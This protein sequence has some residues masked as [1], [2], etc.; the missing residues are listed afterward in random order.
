MARPSAPRFL[1]FGDRFELPVVLQ[2]QTNAPLEVEVVVRT[3]NL[4]LSAATAPSPDGGDNTSYAGLRVTVPA[5][6]RIEVRFPATTAMAGTARL[7][8]A[9]VSGDYSDA[10]I[11]ELPVY[12]PATTEAF[13]T[14]GVIDEGT[15][16][17]PVMTPSG[18]YPTVWRPGDRHLFHRVTSTHRCSAIPGF[19]S[20]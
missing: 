14:Y 1:N 6:D 8:I 17:Q 9:A 16:S 10:A 4:E 12:T 18:V 7:Q 11:V 5:R 20:F 2:N 3:S 13:A 19:L 15:V